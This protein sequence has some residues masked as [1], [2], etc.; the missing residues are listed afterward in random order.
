[1]NGLV[2]VPSSV[3]D[4]QCGVTEL[5]LLRADLLPQWEGLVFC[6]VDE[7]R[8]IQALAVVTFMLDSVSLS[9]LIVE[10]DLVLEIMTLMVLH[11][12]LSQDSEL[13]RLQQLEAVPNP[14]RPNQSH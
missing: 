6:L 12:G 3:S 11:I 14:I 9:R 8:V 10:M 5:R 7:R 4:V 13:F 2:G 1:M